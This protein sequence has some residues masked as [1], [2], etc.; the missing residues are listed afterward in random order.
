M[1]SGFQIGLSLTSREADHANYKD[2][3]C[4]SVRTENIFF[5]KEACF[6]SMI[7]RID[8]DFQ[9]ISYFRYY[10][11]YGHVETMA[12]EI[13]R[14]ANSVADVEATLWRVTFLISLL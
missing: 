10:S 7:S 2:L 1:I 13:Q 6:I 11:L 9:L 8:E 14:G 12:R 4:V 3:Y 5:K